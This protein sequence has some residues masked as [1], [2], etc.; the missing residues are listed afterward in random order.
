MADQNDKISCAICGAQVHV[1]K[2]HLEQAHPEVTLEQYEIENPTSPILSPYAEQV[3][4][5]SA[6]KKAAEAAAVAATTDAGTTEAATAAPKEKPAANAA[7]LVPP[8]GIVRKSLHEVFELGATA[9]AMNAKGDPIP[10]ATLARHDQQDLVPKISPDYIYLAD[11]LKDVILALEVK[12]PCYVWGHKGSGKSELFEQ[13]AAR[14]NRPMMRVQHSANTEESHIIGQWT[15]KGGNTHFELGPLAMAMKFGWLYVADEYDFAQPSVL[16]VYQPVL[17]G[18]ALVIKEAPAEMRIIEPHPNF[19][20]VATGN[21]NGSGDESGLYQG[22]LIQNSANYDRFG[23]V[24]HKK[25]MPEDKESIMLQKRAKLTAKDAD[26]MVQFAKEIRQAFDG[27][28]MSDTVSP[29][30]L[31][32][33]SQIGIMRGSFA[34]GLEKSFISKLSKVDR[35]VAGGIAQRIFGSGKK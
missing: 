23:M 9:E 30:T 19:R 16:A 3:V 29:R 1:M 25:Y 27:A 32:Y 13:V 2:K 5:A 11:E 22:T 21:T 35:E 20:M 14:T 28:K 10:I 26:K 4:A 8:T 31:I 18:K 34:H 33:A 15:V 17:E 6:K 24:I 7:A 12:I